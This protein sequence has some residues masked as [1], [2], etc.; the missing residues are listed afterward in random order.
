MKIE[1]RE[2]MNPNTIRI[3]TPDERWYQHPKT[4]AWVPSATWIADYCPKGIGF[5]KWLAEKGWDEAQA[6]LVLAGNKGS[7]VHNACEKLALDGSINIR[8]DVFPDGNGDEKDLTEEELQCVFSFAQW[9][10]DCSPKFLAIEKT[11]FNEQYRYAGTLDML[12]EIGGVKYIVDIKT[13]ANIYL[14]HE[15]QIS[16][17]FHADGIVA[18]KM[19]ILQVGYNR[20]KTGYKFTEIS[21]KFN[22]FLS[23]LEFWKDE[24]ENKNPHQKDYPIELKI[25]NFGLVEMEL[26]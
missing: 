2:I 15:A 16:S 20:N 13:S 26:V 5:Y 9:C 21:D 1:I 11:V 12:V 4:K 24:N 3:T 8:E 6:Q 7:R 10:N 17:Y 14:S 18:D 23:A 22:I 19:A 25:E